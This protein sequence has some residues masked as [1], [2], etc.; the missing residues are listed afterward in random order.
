MLSF[1]HGWC[2]SKHCIQHGSFLSVSCSRW[3]PIRPVLVAIDLALLTGSKA[4]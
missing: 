1:R 2:D 4:I 3:I